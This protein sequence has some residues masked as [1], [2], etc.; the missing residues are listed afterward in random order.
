LKFLKAVRELIIQC[1]DW[2][3][4]PFKQLIPKQTFRYA[5]CGGANTAFD[6]F[7]YF[8]F[9][10]YILK[11]NDFDLGFIALKPHIAAFFMTFPI[12]FS[13][14]FILSKYITFTESEIRGKVQLIRYGLT[15]LMCIILNYIFLKIFVE[16]FKIYPTPSKILSTGLVVIY[17]Y[18][19]QKYFTFKMNPKPSTVKE[20]EEIAI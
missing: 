2:F 10:N 4:K 11:K 5:F 17:S 9:Y 3:Y 19:S 12:T 1:I 7:L 6:I 8:I 14:G 15:V 16:V 20:F 18:F 13:T